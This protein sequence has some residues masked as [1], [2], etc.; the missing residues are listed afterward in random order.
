MAKPNNQVVEPD[1][2]VNI[3][4]DL[5]VNGDVGPGGF[6]VS[7][8]VIVGYYLGGNAGGDGV[9]GGDEPEER[10][11]PVR[12]IEVSG[13]A[14]EGIYGGRGHRIPFSKWCDAPPPWR[15]GVPYF[16]IG[17]PKDAEDGIGPFSVSQRPSD[18]LWNWFL[19]FIR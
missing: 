6:S 13:T 5:R 18:I 16:C 19:Q 1:Q 4:G 12:V 11:V 7:G 14:P 2:T 17:D 3:I 8:V 10:F 15:V 9:P